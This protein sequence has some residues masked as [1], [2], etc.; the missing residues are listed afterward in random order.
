MTSGTKP[1]TAAELM[2]LLRHEGQTGFPLEAQSRL[3]A[4]M[5]TVVAVGD[6]FSG[7]AAHTSQVSPSASA[8]VFEEPSV[9][10]VDRLSA[11]LGRHPIASLVTAV[12]LGGI[13]GAAGHSL[14]TTRK[15]AKLDVAQSV[16][17]VS[18]KADAIAAASP[19]QAPVASIDE[20]PL[21]APSRVTAEHAADPRRPKPVSIEPAGSAEPKA[22]PSIADQ[23]A[24]L[25][26]ARTALG[27]G[28]TNRALKLLAMH[29]KEYPASTLSEEREALAVK[30]LARAGRLAE[31]KTRLAQFEAQFPGS[32]MLSTLRRA[33]GE[34][35]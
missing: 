3:A 32:L 28:D 33:V 17:R 6:S 22:S 31:A 23:L 1:L 15:L 24:M 19:S 20:L 16:T 34:I 27:R 10:V 11:L 14:Y 8:G 30:S 29:A 21:I 26:Q 12:T 9:S 35:P 13:F 5:L 7:T 18:A 2:Q 4:R 25:E